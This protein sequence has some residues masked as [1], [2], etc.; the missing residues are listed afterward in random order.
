M[1]IGSAYESAMP[2]CHRERRLTKIF[3]V[4][5][6]QGWAP[7]RRDAVELDAELSQIHFVL[8]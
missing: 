1:R 5:G 7:L 2:S 3:L 4:R 8:P 6:V